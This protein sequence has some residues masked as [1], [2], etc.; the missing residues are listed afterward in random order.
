MDIK[1]LDAYHHGDMNDA[2]NYLGCH[3]NSK[4]GTAVFR[5]WSTRATK[6]S[7]IGDFNGWDENADPMTKITEAGI[8]EVTVK[9]VKPFDGYKFYIENGFGKPIYKCDPFA[10]H[11]ETFEGTNAKV[12]DVDHFKWTDADYI[13]N[14]RNPY[15]APM[16]V[17]EAHVGSWRRYPDGNPFD[18]RK[19][20]DEMSEIGRASCRERVS[21]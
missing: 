7:V 15:D 6:I 9:G 18:Y 16:S 14:K 3:F 8:W 10:F 11:R 20:A 1:L 19:F 5:V 21:A 12:V 2:Y 17:Y 13:K 4:T